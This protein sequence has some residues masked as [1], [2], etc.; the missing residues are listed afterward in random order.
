MI[1]WIK[2]RQQL[3]SMILG[4]LML[5]AGIA[6]LFWDNR[7]S[8]ELSEE[9]MAA[10]RVA[11]YEARMQQQ[12]Q[13]GSGPEPDKPLLSKRFEAHQQKQLRYAV[14]LLLVGGVGFMGYSFYRKFG[15]ASSE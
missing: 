13:G 12:M 6:M 7:G 2:A 3:L 14:I 4:A 15:S 10:E 11:R 5:V 1:E 8:A 9:Q